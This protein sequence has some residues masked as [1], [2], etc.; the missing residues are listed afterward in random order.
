MVAT[1]T[2]LADEN[3]LPYY[4]M[5]NDR[6]FR[7]GNIISPG[8]FGKNFFLRTFSRKGQEGNLLAAIGERLFNLTLTGAVGRSL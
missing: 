5:H 3:T 1:K 4:E 2:D 8:A 7:G 6:T